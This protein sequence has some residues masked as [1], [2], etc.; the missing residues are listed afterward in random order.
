MRKAEG[1]ALDNVTFIEPQPFE[2]MAEVLALADA[3]LVSLKDVPLYRV[4]MPSKIQANMASGQPIIAALAGDA[5]RVVE[6]ANC[7]VTTPPGDPQALAAAIVDMA[8]QGK[9]AWCALGKRARSYYQA[10]F[11]EKSVGDELESIL[12]QHRKRR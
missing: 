9:S 1:L 5:A 8:N 7:G 4:T 3:Q 2:L 12:S 6:D 11:S 10:N